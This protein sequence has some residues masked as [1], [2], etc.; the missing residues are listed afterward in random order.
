MRRKVAF[1]ERF[2][3]RQ[4]HPPEPFPQQ[5]SMTRFPFRRL[6]FYALRRLLY[7]W[8]RSDIIGQ[9][10]QLRLDPDKPVFY[11]LQQ[12]SASDLAVLDHECLASGLPRPVTPI[13]LG[14]G[15]EPAAFFYLAPQPGWLGRPV[16]QGM[17]PTLARITEA[18]ESGAMADVQIVP[19]SVFWGQSPDRETSPWKLLFADSWAVTGRLRK[20]LCILVLG[21][22]TRVQ[23]SSPLHVREALGETPERS[24]RRINRL[25]RV[26][27]RDQKIAVI[28]PDL[29]HR[30][31]LVREL[32]RKPAVAQAILDAAQHEHIAPA[33]AKARALK[34][35]NEIASNFSYPVLRF[36]E[37]LLSW[38][39]NRLYDG[40]RIQHIEQV[41]QLARGRELVYVPCHRSH[42]DYLL[43]SYL[44]FHNGL[45]AP[46]IAAGI[47][48]DMPL[49]GGLLRRGGA[50]FMRRSFKD[51]PL[52]TA[53]F[54]EYLHTLFSRGFPVEYFVEGG[55]SRTG[56]T[57]QPKTGMLAITLRSYLRS[58]RLPV[59]FVPVYIGYERVFEGRTYLGELRGKSKK[60]E[61]ILDL[62]KVFGAL[63]QRFGQVWVNFGE[64]LELGDFLDREQPGWRERQADTQADW[65]SG[66]TRRLAAQVAQRINAAAAINPVNLVAL[67]LLATPR[68]AL[69]ERALVRV[70]D[71]FLALLRRVPYSAHTTLPDGDGQALVDHARGMNLLAEQQDALGKVMFLDEQNAVLMTYYRN[72]IL[73]MFAL[74]ALLAS[75]F[76]N[77]SRMSREQVRLY[78]Q[79]LYP[80]LRAELFMRWAPDELEAV[81]EQ[82]LEAF[83][84]QQL[85]RVEGDVY[86]RPAPSSRHFALL[87]LLSRTIVQTLQ[88]FYMASALLLDHPQNSLSA[89]ALE[90]LCVVMAQRLSILHGLNAPEFFDKSLFRHFID[91]LLAQGVLRRD[92]KGLLSHH[93]RLA[94]LAEGAARRVLPAEVRLS[95]RQMAQERVEDGELP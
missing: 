37:T 10:A 49:I 34:Y 7:V 55:R 57:L 15:I 54:N 87:T 31:T 56:R 91:T 29:S 43:L 52:Y 90:E 64:P 50:F 51:N 24:M 19:V 2:D 41:Q 45:S 13:D 95:I 76:Q 83:V 71:R 22:M 88:R 72:N 18:V 93:P 23:L 5:T 1:A 11:A 74:P 65:L 89:E 12:P 44:L 33:K 32:V 86:V 30:R 48:L 66:T 78:V 94:E 35:A 16:R 70:L 59:L 46:H 63:K 36:L 67:A 21:R 38:F 9:V 80:Y 17:S 61:S 6:A 85:L 58:S 82:W 25:L 47:N 68:Q 3:M 77:N 73:H 60:K 40:I 75:L 4:T 92:D 28:G 84:E 26:Q 8:V 42:I 69:D 27:L 53:V 39:W 14:S 20:L 62:F 81:V 79:A